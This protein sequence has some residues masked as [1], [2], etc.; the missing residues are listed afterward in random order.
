MISPTQRSLAL[1][2]EGNFI[3]QVV[4]RWNPYAKVRVDLFG[5]IDIVAVRHPYP[6][7][8]GIQT[9]SASNMSARIKKILGIPEAKI[10]LTAGNRIIV[11]GWSKKGRAG[12]RKTWQYNV[13]EITLE[14]FKKESPL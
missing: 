2:K 9:T 14:D 11:H 10:W 7:V 6:G 5:F 1:L 8:I 3:C 12:A 13:T 4:E